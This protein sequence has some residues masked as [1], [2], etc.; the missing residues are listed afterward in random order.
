MIYTVIKWREN[1]YIER[2]TCPWKTGNIVRPPP[3][4][5]FQKKAHFLASLQGEVSDSLHS[6]PFGENLTFQHRN[7]IA[8]CAICIFYLSNRNMHACNF[9]DVYSRYESE[10]KSCFITLAFRC[11]PDVHFF[12]L[13]VRGICCWV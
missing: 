1:R 8:T 5:C 4:P 13:T 2:M 12:P 6:H 7:L 11:T 10:S 9:L 3:L